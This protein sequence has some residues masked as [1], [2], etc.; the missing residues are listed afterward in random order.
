MFNYF[1]IRFF[2]GVIEPEKNYNSAAE[3]DKYFA[4]KRRERF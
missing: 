4:S 1:P 2:D 3:A